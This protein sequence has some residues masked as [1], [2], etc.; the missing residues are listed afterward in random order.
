MKIAKEFNCIP[1]FLTFS[2]NLKCS[3]CINNDSP[4]KNRGYEMVGEDWINGLN[5]LELEND[6]TIELEGGE[7]TKH[8]DFYS[9]IE[10][11][12]YPVDILTNLQFNVNKFISKVDPGWFKKGTKHWY[13]SLRASYHASQMDANKTIEKLVKL[14]DANFD[15][16]LSSLNLPEMS[17]TNMEMTELARMNGIYFTIK[18][19]LGRRDGILHGF[20]KYPD[21]LSGN[22]KDVMCRT[23]DLSI[24]PN[25]LVY[26]CH[27][28]LYAGENTL[29]HL[30]DIK[31][32]EFK[33]RPCSNYGICHPCDVKEKVNKFLEQGFSNVEIKC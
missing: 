11:V 18:E 8:K 13:K 16:A 19:F 17:E 20:Y 25:G 12:K 10:H 26:K 15:V 2:C 7:P 14:Q 31:S 27:R 29:G 1:V 30:S 3:Y 9:I 21:A 6:I 4:I 5:N 33:Y 22:K 28:D 24:A 23:R 32:I